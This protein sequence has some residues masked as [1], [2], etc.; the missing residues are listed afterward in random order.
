[1]NLSNHQKG[2]KPLSLSV[3]PLISLLATGCDVY[4]KALT[5]IR[6]FLCAVSQRTDRPVWSFL[7]RLYLH[8]KVQ[9]NVGIKNNFISRPTV[10]SSTL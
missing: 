8:F 7:E 5:L 2:M 10:A 3:I 9:Q 4:M 1:M 6:P